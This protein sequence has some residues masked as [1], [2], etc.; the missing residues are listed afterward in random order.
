MTGIQSR[1]FD[2]NEDLLAIGK[3]V[4]ANTGERIPL[5]LCID[6]SRSMSNRIRQINESILSFLNRTNNNDSAC[7]S[8]KVQLITFGQEVVRSENCSFE[9]CEESSDLG[10]V[11]DLFEQHP[12]LANGS[13]TCL[14]KAVR[15]SLERI[16]KYTKFLEDNGRLYRTPHLLIFSDGR[17]TDDCSEI[18]RIVQ[19][20]MRSREKSRRIKVFCIGLGTEKNDLEKF[21][22]SGRTDYT[23]EDTEIK[24]FFWKLSEQVSQISTQNINTGRDA[25]ESIL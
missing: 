15:V 24:E 10:M 14:G 3:A 2:N 13:A 18:S 9:T 7:N 6:I 16:D 4:H 8:V 12:L 23:L 20:R 5:C 1:D 11:I 25:V 22:L 21:S 19:E 17:A